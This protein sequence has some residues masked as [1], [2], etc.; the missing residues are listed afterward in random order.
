[1]PLENV[2]VYISPMMKF[3][4]FFLFLLFANPDRAELDSHISKS[5]KYSFVKGVSKYLNVNLREA[6]SGDSSVNC[7]AFS[8]LYVGK[9][10]ASIIHR[11]FFTKCM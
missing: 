4:A 3:I 11:N 10:D 2:G 8:Y 7:Y 1:M 9:G 6:F 5:F